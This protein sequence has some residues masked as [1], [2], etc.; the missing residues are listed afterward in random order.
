MKDIRLILI[1]FIL[2][3]IGACQAPSRQRLAADIKYAEDSLRVGKTE[4]V[5]R[6]A[7][8]HLV[9]ANDSDTYYAWLTILNR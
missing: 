7:S 5:K 6:M 3:G 8:Q 4:A 9:E 2:V 1:L